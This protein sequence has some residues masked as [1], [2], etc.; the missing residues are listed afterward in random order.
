MT[1]ALHARVIARII[2][3][4]LLVGFQGCA[5]TPPSS[6]LPES[7]QQQLGKICLLIFTFPSAG[8]AHYPFLFYDRDPAPLPAPSDPSA[9]IVGIAVDD[10]DIRSP[11]LNFREVYF[12]KFEDG[13]SE[14]GSSDEVMR[15]RIVRSN[16]F[17]DG[18]I[19]LLNAQPGRY[20]AIGARQFRDP[21]GH[22]VL[23][24][25]SLV[26]RL[27]QTVA[28]GTVALLGDITVKQT[29]GSKR[30]S[31][32]DDFQ[33]HYFKELVGKDVRRVLDDR[34]FLGLQFPLNQTAGSL[35]HEEPLDSASRRFKTI[36]SPILPKEWDPWFSKSEGSTP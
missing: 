36:L 10:K 22:I 30:G 2:G 29:W 7:I 27:T 35:Y 1:S 33:Q 11:Y 18:Y 25:R 4:L 14:D 12:V 5:H 34:R 3:L 19:Y 16:Y 9:V 15:G 23:F 32:F 28:P 26:S 31:D 6:S 8:C 21:R 20:T 17:R 24:D 13:S